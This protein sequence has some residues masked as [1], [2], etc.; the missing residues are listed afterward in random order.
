MTR[1]RLLTALLAAGFAWG[2][3]YLLSLQFESGEVYP[4]YSSLRADPL[5]SK[6]LFDTLARVPGVTVSRNFTALSELAP[7]TTVLLLG[8]RPAG[9]AEDAEILRKTA[10]R[11]VRVV[12]AMDARAYP[13]SDV[14]DKSW[15]LPL[16]ID[17]ES[18]H[19]HP[20][21]FPDARDWT[22]VDRAGPKILALEKSFG[23]GT[24]AL[25]AES[26]DFANQS[27]AAGDRFDT[28][29]RALGPNLRVVFDERHF[30]IAE[31][32]S[33]I[34][35]AR[36]FHM[37]GFALGL[38]LCAAL[39]LWR[40]AAAFPPPPAASPREMLAGRTSHSGL[41]TLLRRNIPRDQLAAACWEEWRA[42]NRLPK[43]AARV[44]RAAAIVREAGSRPLQAMR[45]VQSVLQAK[46]EL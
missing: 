35:L 42:G 12:A 16:A 27:T 37:T 11:G 4:E 33:V 7:G 8:W 22:V 3:I 32:G 36:R 39:L 45:E 13:Q 38:G 6:L 23:K 24:V 9:L 14:L 26:D 44:D 19:S 15:G 20:L 2:V 18:R 28:V 5:G 43:D 46:G 30:G 41:V 17:R 31:S 1:S 34:A 21:Y 40:N 29:A 10:G 25:W